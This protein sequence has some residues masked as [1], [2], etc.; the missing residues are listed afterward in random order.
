[1]KSKIGNYID[2]DYYINQ[3]EVILL[4][5]KLS[6]VEKGK[7]TQ[8]FLNLE[9]HGDHKINVLCSLSG[10]GNVGLNSTHIRNAFWVEFLPP[11]LDF[12]PEIGRARRVLPPY[13]IN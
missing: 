8:F 7:Y 9:H 6:K 13:P 10:V 4:H 3:H 11:P 12:V 2:A 5:V 1:M